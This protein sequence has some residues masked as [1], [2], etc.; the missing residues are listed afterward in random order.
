MPLDFQSVDTETVY[1]IA[2]D[3]QASILA[4]EG[5]KDMD[6]MVA[7]MRNKT[8][9]LLPVDFPLEKYMVEIVGTIYC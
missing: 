5:Y 9:D 1:F 8:K 4:G 3:K 7:E 6:E 2:L